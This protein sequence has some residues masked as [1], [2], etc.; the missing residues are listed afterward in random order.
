[1]FSNDQNIE[2]IAKFV[3]ESKQWFDLKVK[4]AR[5]S[6]GAKMVRIITALILA[7]VLTIIFVL[8]LTFMSFA[9]ADFLGDILGNT[10]LGF[11]CVGFVYLVLLVFVISARHAL[12]E[13]P[14]VR[15][16]MS[17]IAEDE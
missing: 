16:L 8:F 15:F 1:M 14:L 7:I 5:L 9:L 13:R 6:T 10:P 17:I 4:Y 11:L 12:I 2:L 3:E